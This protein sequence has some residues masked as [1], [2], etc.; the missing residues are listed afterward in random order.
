MNEEKAEKAIVEKRVTHETITELLTLNRE[1]YVYRFIHD[2]KVVTGIS[3]TGAKALA[4]Y[5]NITIIDADIK[6]INEGFFGKAKAEW[7]GRCSIGGAFQSK[8]MK[9]KN[10]RQLKDDKASVKALNK[11]QRNAI[12]NL[13][14]IPKYVVKDV[15]EE[16]VEKEEKAVEKEEI[17]T[18][19]VQSESDTNTKY[20]VKKSTKGWECSCPSFQFRKGPCKHIKSVQEKE[21]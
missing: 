8:I 5:F 7:H 10:G 15:S 16:K 6:E 18:W 4:E 9:L 1:E 20:V 17:Q 3:W 11:A 14:P 21:Q 19:E 2:G 13:L 12:L